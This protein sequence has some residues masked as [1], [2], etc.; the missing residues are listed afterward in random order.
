VPDLGKAIYT[1]EVDNAPFEAGM[2]ETEATAASSTAAVGAKVDSIG[3]K[4]ESN[5]LKTLKTAKHVSGEAAKFVALPVLAL[6]ALSVDLADKQEAATRQAQGIFGRYTKFITDA[7]GRQAKSVGLSSLAYTDLA[8]KIGIAVKGAGVHGKALVTT[9]QTL[10]TEAANMSTATG[11]SVD[12]ITQQISAAAS[13]RAMALKKYGI[14]IDSNA[15]KEYALAH[16]IGVTNTYLQKRSEQLHTVQLDQTKY[17]AALAASSTA[18]KDANDKLTLA[19]QRYDDA[20]KKDGASS[21]TAKSAAL[22]L[23]SAKQAV[24]KATQ[25][26]G[27]AGATAR[28]A[29][30]TL[31]RAQ[32]SYKQTLQGTGLTLTAQAKAQAV[33]GI[34]MSH[35]GEQA[36]RAAKQH[37]TFGFELKQTKA[38][39]EN[40]M[41]KLGTALIPAVDK[42]IH[43][44]A[45][46]VEWLGK[47]QTVAKILIIALG[48]L[49]SIILAVNIATRMM[50][51]WDKVATLQKRLFATATEEQ[52]AATEGQA[53][54]TEGA[55]GAMAIFNAIMDANPIMLVVIAIVALIAIFV[56]LYL[57][58]GFVHRAVQAA[59]HY[60]MEGIDFVKA[61]WKV[62]VMAIIAL[63]AP[64]LAVLILLVTHFGQVKSAVGSAMS[65]MTGAISSAVSTVVGFFQ[66]IWGRI[67]NSVSNLAGN[68][69]QAFTGAFTGVGDIMWSSFKTGINTLIGWLN[70]GINDVVAAE[71]DIPFSPNLHIPH[72]PIPTLARGTRNFAGGLAMVGELGPELVTLPRGAGVSTASATRA[73]L[74]GGGGGGR[75]NGRLQIDPSLMEGTID[76][77]IEDGIDR[78]DDWKGGRN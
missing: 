4:V 76:A 35:A 59:F 52:T 62:A 28:G 42:L 22:S 55:S 71:K 67:Q 49:A 32:T 3:K 8:D 16:H 63:F 40:L 2:A 75:I 66:G 51:F 65:A 47:H 11:A 34:V 56:V 19:Q 37:H 43:G 77:L 45:T 21:T 14:Y 74:G 10:A 41:I 26:D 5:N 7:S 30:L 9:T 50:L 68:V 46:S 64:W 23:A 60:F 27:K 53:T 24:T 31:Q 6:G 13:G 72:N 48:A 33:M 18:V 57:K 44:V 73:M 12:T 29:L 54:A 17:N 58:V 36:R 69:A 78:Y 25:D 70:S 1:V 38:E 20:V 61:H 39:A 15:I